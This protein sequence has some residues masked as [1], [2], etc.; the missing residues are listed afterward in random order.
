[1]AKIQSK[2]SAPSRRSSNVSQSKPVARSVST[3]S[4]QTRKLDTSKDSAKVSKEARESGA[5]SRVS[6]LVAGM[7][8]WG[9]SEAPAVGDK[10]ADSLSLG[11][12]ELLRKGMSGDKIRQL[13]EL[14]N[15]KGAQLDPDGKFGNDTLKAL[16]AFQKE[17]KLGSDGVVGSKTLEKL[18]G[19]SDGAS[20]NRAE[21]TE[22]GK[23]VGGGAKPGTEQSQNSVEQPGVGSGDGRFG[24]TRAA[25]DKLP[26][27]LKKYAD[28][29]QKM[30]EKYGVDPRFLASISMHETG[31]GTSSAFR[32]K[33]NAM[34]ISGRRGPLNMSSVEASIEKMA[35]TLAKPNGY[36]RGKSTIGQI[37]KVYAPVG[38]ANDPSGLNGYWAGGVAKNFKMFGG[39]PSQQVVFRMS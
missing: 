25:L 9:G 23:E 3:N 36:Y 20:R 37:G 30:G 35:N 4:L 32:N 22:P 33:N 29:F 1:M 16:K 27:G 17:S 5:S 39:D 13:Q 7:Q 2:V 8:E 31:N 28:V 18:N 24:D 14:L 11:K 15:S 21:T 34:G 10:K 12:G 26:Q 19:D 6:N 38:A